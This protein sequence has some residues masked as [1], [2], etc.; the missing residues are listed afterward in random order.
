MNLLRFTLP[1]SRSLRL[2]SLA[3][4]GGLCLLTV[5]AGC[6]TSGY[7]KAGQAA[8]SVSDAAR[9]IDLA[10]TQIDQAT[11][12]LD[13][14]VHGPDA[15]LKKNFTPYRDAVMALDATFASV[16]QKADT[17]EKEGQ[18]YFA[19]WDQ[20]LAEINSE[21]LRTRSRER[22]Q[23]ASDRFTQ[24]QESYRDARQ[25]F[26]PLMSKLHDIQR[27]LGVDLTPA[28]VDSVRAPADQASQSAQ[29]LQQ[30][31]AR[32]ASQFR[33]LGTALAPAAGA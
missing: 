22:Q 12:A 31:L 1:K 19:A 13:T 21:D 20:K 11:S 2:N 27:V 29:Q 28:G 17:M 32:L 4:A 5:L 10:R 30:T 23:A 14:L 33:Q 18:R 8:D 15:D 26:A 25:Q 7:Q 6:A 9:E 3:C 16:N 24:I